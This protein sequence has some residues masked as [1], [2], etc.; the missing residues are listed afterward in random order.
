MPGQVEIAVAGARQGVVDLLVFQLGPDRKVRSDADL[1]FFNQ[2]SSPEGAVRL[3]AADRITADLTAVPAGV[4]MLAVAVALDDAA[5][6]SLAAIA[7]LAVTVSGGATSSAESHSAPASGL[8][9]ERA[10]VL[11]EI[12]RRAGAWKVRNVSAGWAAGLSALA[13]EHGVSI[14]DQPA[15]SLPPDQALPPAVL[16]QPAH[17]RSVPAGSATA[18]SAAGA[19][20]RS[21][22][23]VPYPTPGG[24]PPPG[25]TLPP[26]PP[27]RLPTPGGWPAP[28]GSLAGRPD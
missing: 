11:V 24:F 8:S 25:G 10:A 9:V 13:G 20:P 19:R 1:V 18:P 23:Q 16:P 21:A 4:E 15:A 2:P 12:Y 22:G 28:G 17:P 27:F 5:P 3:V 6:G 14:D 7:G 26:P